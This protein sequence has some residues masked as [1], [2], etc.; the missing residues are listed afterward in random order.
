MRR[1]ELPHF[2]VL[3]GLRVV[4]SGSSIASPY[5]PSLMADMG[6]DVIWIE[7]YK[8][9]DIQRTGTSYGY[10]AE[11]DRRNQRT[12]SLNTYSDEGK[13]IFKRMIK[14]TDIFIEGSRGGQWERHGLGDDVLWEINPKLSIVHISG[15]GQYGDPEYVKR[16]SYDPIGQAFGG[17]MYANSDPENP[18]EKVL[19][20]MGM[21]ADYYAAYFAAFSGLSGYIHAQKTGKGESFDISQYESII[22]GMNHL[23]MDIWNLNR[24]MASFADHDRNSGTA[25]YNSFR[26]K[27]GQQIYMLALGGGVMKGLAKLLDVGPDIIPDGVGLLFIDGRQPDGH[28]MERRIIEYCAQHT[29]EEVEKEMNEYGIPCSRVMRFEDMLTHPHYLARESIT[30]WETKDGTQVIGSNVVPKCKNNPGRIWRGC[31][32]KGQDNNDILAD[33]GYSEEEIKELNEKQ[34]VTYKETLPVQV[35]KEFNGEIINP[36]GN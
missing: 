34:I 25:G 20:V 21:M 23:N 26:C 30:H 35:R 31:P 27:D 4:Y 3:E 10:V 12:I 1:S 13:E 2:G 18:D 17:L 32:N 8:N 16:A 22:R 19:P 24:T 5:G 11:Q 7:H 33:L 29:A 14:D 6:A 28:E 15:F 9:A 36:E